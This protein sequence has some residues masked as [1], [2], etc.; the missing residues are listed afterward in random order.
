M[1]RAALWSAGQCSG[2][3][4]RGGYPVYAYVQ[5]LQAVY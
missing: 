1:G 4:V 2:L 5:T 3:S